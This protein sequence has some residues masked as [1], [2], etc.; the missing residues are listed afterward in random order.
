ML[1]A[2]GWQRRVVVCMYSAALWYTQTL[3]QFSWLLH[4]QLKLSVMA[5]L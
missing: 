4:C 2:L 1:R 5:S 3:F